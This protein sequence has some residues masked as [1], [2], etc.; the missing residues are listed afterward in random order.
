MEDLLNLPEL[1]FDER[2]HVYRY[3]GDIILPSVTQIMRPLSIGPYG[4]ISESVLAAAAEKGTAVHRAIEVHCKYGIDACVP[5]YEAYFD[6][7]VQ[8]EQDYRPEYMGSEVRFYHRALMYAGTVD[9]IARVDGKTVLIDYKTTAVL[10]EK[11]CGV[12]LE[13]YAQGLKSHGVEVVEKYILQLK[14][15]GRYVFQR[16]PGADPDRWRVF[17]SLITVYDY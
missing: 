2:S 4:G 7:F 12:Q 6:A 14:K 13:A 5:E 9:C 15:D 1:S 17:L 3:N 10:H 16:F 11:L 8:W